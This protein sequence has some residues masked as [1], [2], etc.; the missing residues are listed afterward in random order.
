MHR[1]ASVRCDAERLIIEERQISG[2]ELSVQA[3]PGW[4]VRYAIAIEPNTGLATEREMMAMTKQTQGGH[5][6]HMDLIVH[7][8]LHGESQSLPVDRLAL[9]IGGSGTAKDSLGE[10]L[11]PPALHIV[12]EGRIGD[13]LIREPRGG[14]QESG[15]DGFENAL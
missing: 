3:D 5:G 11:E 14:D 13:S 10:A 7:D 6:A 2:G 8:V 9:R 12:A 4:P 15:R 1:T